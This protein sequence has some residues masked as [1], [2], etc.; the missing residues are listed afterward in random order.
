MGQAVEITCP[1]CKKIFVVNPHMLGSG[2]DFHCSFCKKT[3][4]KF[5]SEVI[6]LS[7]PASRS[8]CLTASLSGLID[9]VGRRL[10][11]LVDGRVAFPLVHEP[12]ANPELEAQL[13]HV[14]VKGIEVLV[15]HHPRWHM[16]RIPLIPVIALPTDLRIAVPLQGV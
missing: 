1:T 2:M 8:E 11:V 7:T 6:Q 13:F 10:Q 16:H 15:V 3:A 5:A 4:R 14:P 12:I 9:H